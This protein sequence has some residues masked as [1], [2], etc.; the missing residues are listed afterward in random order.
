MI[1]YAAPVVGVEL[2]KLLLVV[3]VLVQLYLIASSLERMDLKEN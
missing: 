2:Y 1:Q 3:E